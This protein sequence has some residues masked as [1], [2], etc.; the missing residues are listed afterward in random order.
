MGRGRVDGACWAGVGGGEA[1]GLLH[2]GEAGVE[3]ALLGGEFQEVK[4]AATM[5]LALMHLRI[6]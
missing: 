6:R 3:A 4:W 5:S 1:Q 2:L